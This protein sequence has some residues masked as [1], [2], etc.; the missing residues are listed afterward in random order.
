MTL[1][2]EITLDIFEAPL[3]E[4]INAKQEDNISRILVVTLTANGQVL[5]P[6]RQRVQAL[7]RA[8]K[9][10]R[11]P[12]DNPAVIGEDGKITVHLTD[13]TLAVPG[14]VKA[15]IT[16]IEGREV[17][18]SATFYIQV[19][20]RQGGVGITSTNEFLVMVEATE[21]AET[22]ADNADTAA[23][24]ANTVAELIENMTVS[25][26]KV[27]AGGTPTAALTKQDG[28]YALALGLVTGDT[29]AKG[30]KG[31][32]PTISIAETV[33]GAPGEPAKVENVGTAT[34]PKLKFTIPLGNQGPVL[35]VN[36]QTGAVQLGGTNLLK[37]TRDFSGDWKNKNAWVLSSGYSGLTVYSRNA[38]WNGIYQ[39]IS[40][41]AGEYV[42][43]AY[44]KTTQPCDVR[45]NID[46]MDATAS[47]SP[48]FAD[49]TCTTAFARYAIPF[50][51]EKDGIISPR[52]S[53]NF[54][55]PT[56]SICGFKLE[57]GN[58]ATDWSPAP[59]DKQDVSTVFS[60][61]LPANAWAD[62][63]QTV[64]DARFLAGDQYDYDVDV[65][66]ACIPWD[67]ITITEGQMTVK[68]DIVPKDT[69]TFMVKRSEVRIDG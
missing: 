28:H 46:G 67:G 40:V 29:G 60:V 63:S 48:G 50:T 36:G 42:F 65:N 62:G 45:L 22:A 4:Y 6:D 58:V 27:A 31:D 23:G 11:T 14:D 8:T 21:K 44:I 3:F 52:A 33:T 59:G 64:K 16:L 54:D 56:L 32:A 7:L 15:E 38:A 1:T 10:D 68:A 39:N 61:T 66:G 30:D 20:P 5:K 69:V 17:L 51:V 57:R 37:G 12:V 24:R 9:P 26:S 49:I 18:T 34:D 41:E 43:S 2:Q 13:Q 35:S 19:E 55:G 25:A 53:L 47:V